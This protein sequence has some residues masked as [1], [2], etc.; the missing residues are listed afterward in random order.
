MTPDVVSALKKM[1]YIMD[2]SRFG[3][4]HTIVDRDG[5]LE[6]GSESSGRG[7]SIVF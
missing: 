3:D 7:K 1:G 6:A 2:N 4:L 5:K